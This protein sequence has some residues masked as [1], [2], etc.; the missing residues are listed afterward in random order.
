LEI[1]NS[2]SSIFTFRVILFCIDVRLI[3]TFFHNGRRFFQKKIPFILN[4]STTTENEIK[5]TIIQNIPQNDIQSIYIHIELNSKNDSFI[6]SSTILLGEHTR[7][8]SDWQKL[9]E[10]PRQTHFGWYQFFG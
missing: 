2:P 1:L 9:I 5:D 8:Q 7:Y 10:Y 4:G 3:V 6:S